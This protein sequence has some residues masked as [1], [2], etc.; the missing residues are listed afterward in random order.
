[1]I[2]NV[3]IWIGENN[4]HYSRLVQEQLFRYGLTWNTG[5]REVRHTNMSVLLVGLG[6]N[7]INCNGISRATFETLP[8]KDLKLVDTSFYS[9][10]A[11]REKICIGGK[12]YYI[13]ELEVALENINPV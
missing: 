10:E 11:V 1:M 7:K 9:L 5:H 12:D 2:E 13:D 8:H 3:K 6:S 4:D